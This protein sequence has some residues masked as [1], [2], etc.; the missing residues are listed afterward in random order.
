VPEEQTMTRVFNFTDLTKPDEHVVDLPVKFLR[1]PRLEV[2]S[3]ELRV[4]PCLP[5]FLQNELIAKPGL[6][7]RL[8]G[9]FVPAESVRYPVDVNVNTDAYI[10]N[11]KIGVTYISGG[12]KNSPTSSMQLVVLERPSWDLHQAES[13]IHPPS[14]AHQSQTRHEAVLPFSEDI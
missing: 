11:Q 12:K 6:L 14:W 10:S 13:T 4:V 8:C 1:K 5:S 7:R 3:V 2:Q 9:L